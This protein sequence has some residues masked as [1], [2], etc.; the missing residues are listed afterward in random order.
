[1]AINDNPATPVTKAI[2]APGQCMILK[3][4]PSSVRLVKNVAVLYANPFMIY[5]FIP[6]I[7]WLYQ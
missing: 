3:S 5:G 7:G 4:T 6:I 1:M 2:P